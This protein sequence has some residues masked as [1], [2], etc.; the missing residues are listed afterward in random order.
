MRSL[1]A[2]ALGLLT[3]AVAVTV[4]SLFHW[5]EADGSRTYIPPEVSLELANRSQEVET[6]QQ[7]RA[8]LLAETARLKQTVAEMKS[9]PPEELTPARRIPFLM[10]SGTAGTPAAAAQPADA[11]LADAVAN[12]DTTALPQIE[13][14]ARQNVG[15]A[16]DALALMADQDNGAALTRVLTSG[17]LNEAGRI[18]ATRLLAATMEVNPDADRL[19]RAL[20]ADP[21][22]DS[23]LLYAALD[24]LG[25]PDFPSEFVQANKLPAPPRYEPDYD[26]RLRLLEA[27]VA[28]TQS[29]EVTFYY[30]RARARIAQSEQAATEQSAPALP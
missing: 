22:T 1:A 9:Q 21:K 16:L 17:A 3:G 30:Q 19:L 14:L 23:Q 24:G 10:P 2:F 5:G 26:A 13:Q 28:G 25:A 11:W 27:L 7:E 20:F 6:L 15:E 29:E 18:R 4:A 8:R 12:V